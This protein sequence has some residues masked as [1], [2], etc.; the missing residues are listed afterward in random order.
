MNASEPRAAPPSP[1]NCSLVW[2]RQRPDYARQTTKALVSKPQQMHA[3]MANG[4]RAMV[5]RYWR[6][7]A[8]CSGCFCIGMAQAGDSVPVKTLGDWQVVR[9]GT[10]LSAVAFDKAGSYVALRCEVKQQGCAHVLSFQ[11]VCDEGK[12]YPVL[13]STSSGAYSLNFSCRGISAPTEL[14][15]DSPRGVLINEILM[16][17]DFIGFSISASAGQFKTATFSL[18]GAAKAMEFV[19]RY[20]VK[21]DDIEIKL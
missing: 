20:T 18:K 2:A 4:A 19:K 10:D 12:N 6:T 9:N 16:Q 15:I 13:A 11:A 3:N 14:I 1:R 8:V 7:L 21:Q 5:G 17:G